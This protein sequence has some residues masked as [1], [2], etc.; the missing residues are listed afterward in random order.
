MPA[1]KTSKSKKPTPK[2][3]KKIDAP[4]KSTSGPVGYRPSKPA[5][6]ITHAAEFKNDALIVKT[7]GFDDIAGMEDLK[8][9][10]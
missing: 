5:S 7:G 3:A 4:K 2:S 8:E 9:A 10:F 1:K 6:E